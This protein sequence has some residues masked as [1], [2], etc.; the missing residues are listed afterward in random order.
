MTLHRCQAHMVAVCIL[1]GM[2]Q[3]AHTR[4]HTHAPEHPCHRVSHHDDHLSVWSEVCDTLGNVW[5]ARVYGAGVEH[6]VL[7]THRHHAHTYRHQE[8]ASVRACVCLDCLLLSV[9]VCVC[10]RAPKV[11]HCTHSKC[12]CRTCVQQLCVCVC[13]CVCVYLFTLSTPFTSSAHH[14]CMTVVKKDRYRVLWC[15]Q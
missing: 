14:F 9:C 12:T 2:K 1:K 13:V 5:Q 8:P 10:V 15:A 4:T 6:H 7:R 11:P 3:Q